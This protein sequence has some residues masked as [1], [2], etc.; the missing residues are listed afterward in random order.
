MK[1]VTIEIDKLTNSIVNR[2]TGDVFDTEIESAL[3]KDLKF[4]TK[5]NG[6][7][8]NWKEEAKTK[9]VYKLHIVGNPAIVQGLVSLE[10]AND[11][12]YLNLAESAP[13]NRGKAKMYEGVG[14]NLFAYACKVAFE[15]GYQGYVSFRAKTALIQHYTDSLGAKRLGSSTLMVIETTEAKALIDRYF[16]P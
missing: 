5:K 6:W 15:K 16:K 11:H 3:S 12:I 2:V 7:S 1:K 14:G 9:D 4:I 13:F 8:F 10:D